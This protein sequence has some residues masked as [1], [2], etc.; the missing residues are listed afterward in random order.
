[1]T[2]GAVRD[3]PDLISAINAMTRAVAGAGPEARRCLESCQQCRNS[4]LYVLDTEQYTGNHSLFARRLAVAPDN[5][6]RSHGPLSPVDR[7]RPEIRGV[8]S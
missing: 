1:M 5:H 4:L 2:A 7:N 3:L 8:R 6:R